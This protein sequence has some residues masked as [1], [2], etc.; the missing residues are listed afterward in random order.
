MKLTEYVIIHLYFLSDIA[1]KKSKLIDV[2]YVVRFIYLNVFSIDRLVN[3]LG[4]RKSDLFYFISFIE[5]MF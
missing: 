4:V 2:S 5:S 3:I 1:V